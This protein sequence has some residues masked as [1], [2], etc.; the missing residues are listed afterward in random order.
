MPASLESIEA[1]LNAVAADVAEIKT[2]I[3]AQNGRLRMLETSQ[4][5]MQERMTVRTAL[6]TGAAALMSVAAAFVGIKVR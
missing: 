1:M 2:D 6:T 5:V 3:K 4:A